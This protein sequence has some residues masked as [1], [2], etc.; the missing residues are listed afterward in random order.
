MNITLAMFEQSKTLLGIDQL[1]ESDQEALFNAFGQTIFQ[2]TLLQFLHTQSE[3]EQTSFEA[4]IE[5]HVAESDMLAQLLL[6]YPDF[7][8]ILTQEILLVAETA[9]I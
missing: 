9:K 4:W 5:A 2:N 8:K 3:W 1:S 6:L 7:G